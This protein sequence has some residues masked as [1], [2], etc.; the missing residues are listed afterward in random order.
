MVE[1][2]LIDVTPL[3]YNYLITRKKL[4]ENDELEDFVSPITEFRSE[5]YADT[6][7]KDLKKGDI[8]QFEEGE[9]FHG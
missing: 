5:A 4:E 3:N 6:N 8:I 2:S 9:S 1:Y 7:I